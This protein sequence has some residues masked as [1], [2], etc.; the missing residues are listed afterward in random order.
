MKIKI[1]SCE[2][3]IMIDIILQTS[4]SKVKIVIYFKKNVPIVKFLVFINQEENKNQIVNR[5]FN[6]LI[7]PLIGQKRLFTITF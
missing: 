3:K 6:F 2:W 4:E 1:H 7:L 5:W